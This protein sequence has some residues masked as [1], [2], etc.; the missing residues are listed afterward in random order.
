MSNQT[1][2][3]HQAQTEQTQPPT[4]QQL[5][6]LLAG[7]LINR[8]DFDDVPVAWW[9]ELVAAAGKHQVL[10]LL[11]ETFKQ[12]Q[13]YLDE[14]WQAQLIRYRQQQMIAAGLREHTTYHINQLLTQA[15]ITPLWLKGMALTYTVYDKP[16]QRPMIDIDF[17][18]PHDQQAA[19]LR[20]LVQQGYQFPL[21]RVGNRVLTPDEYEAISHHRVLF[22]PKEPY[23][24]IEMHFDF[25]FDLSQHH[26]HQH[27][28]RLIDWFWQQTRLIPVKD[29]T[30]CI[31]K[32]EASFLYLAAHDILQHDLIYLEANN[33]IDINLRRKYDLYLVAQRYDLN[34]QLIFKQ[35][36]IFGWTYA[37]VESI[38][39]IQQYFD[40]PVSPEL[41]ALLQR[42]QPQ[43]PNI[44]ASEKR[45]ALQL[46]R[47]GQMTLPMQLRYIWFRLLFPPA[48][49]M[50]DIY[51]L[52][53][54][55]R[56]WPYYIRRIREKMPILL[57]L[58]YKQWQTKES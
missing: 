31:L 46:G 57:R 34:W 51:K 55:Q 10:L 23:P 35:A 9:P 40:Y 2:F 54:K 52:S 50:R 42:T 38:K 26:D 39:Q 20:L 47:L 4:P 43:M 48:Q 18:V 44:R 15:E 8:L 22:P 3:G 12:A 25:H 5:I 16:W 36:A 33:T 24:S 21:P 58:L 7:L 53:P 28:G 6:D 37:I 13:Q 49:T 29:T 17:L 30:L 19:A 11:H 32:P 14:T 56:V 27:H 1:T 45:I 41:A